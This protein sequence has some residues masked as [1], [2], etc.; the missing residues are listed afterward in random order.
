MISVIPFAL[1]YFIWSSRWVCNVHIRDVESKLR[2]G[3]LLGRGSLISYFFFSNDVFVYSS[4]MVRTE[5]KTELSINY[6]IVVLEI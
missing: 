1:R 6:T 5:L 2:F 4:W 3:S